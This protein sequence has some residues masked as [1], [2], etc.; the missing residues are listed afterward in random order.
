MS[1]IIHIYMF[2]YYVHFTI[3]AMLRFDIDCT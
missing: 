1:C 2:Q 3:F